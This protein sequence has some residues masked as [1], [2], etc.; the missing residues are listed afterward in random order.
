MARGKIQIKRIENPT[1][2]QVTYSKRRS[3][4]FK[5]AK[6]LTVLCDATVSIIMFSSSN[7]L[8]EFLSPGVSMKE[9]YDRYQETT[10]IDIWLTQY[11]RMQEDLQKLNEINKGLQ[12]QI[13]QRMGDCLE[14]LSFDQLSCLEQDMENAVQFIRQRK[15]KVIATQIDTKNK[16]DLPKEEPPYGLVDDGDYNHVLRYDKSS[17]VL[18]LRL[19]PYPLPPNLHAGGAA[20]TGSGSCVT[21]YT[22]H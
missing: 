11:Q 21:T 6:E 2:R 9:I 8:H 15:Y 5:K 18:A 17:H 22:L 12:R 7:K 16:K 4:L 14:D 1:N 13:R 19:Q 10:G 3:G 20:G